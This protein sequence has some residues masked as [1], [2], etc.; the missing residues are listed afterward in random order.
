MNEEVVAFWSSELR[1]DHDTI[2]GITLQCTAKRISGYSSGIWNKDDPLE[3]LFPALILRITLF[4]FISRFLYVLLRPL[5][6]S[7]TVCNTL[8]GFILGPFSDKFIKNLSSRCNQPLVLFV[9]QHWAWVGV[10]YHVFLLGVKMDTSVI[11]RTGKKV[12]TI[13]LAGVL[14]S[15]VGVPIWSVMNSGTDIIPMKQGVWMVLLFSTSPF[16]IVAEALEELNLLTSELG[17]FA[18]SASMLIDVLRW[19][20]LAVDASVL[21][22]PYAFSDTVKRI[23]A[24]IGLILLSVYVMRPMMQRIVKRTPEKQ[25]VASV[26]HFA[27]LLAV[28]L[29]AF[30]SLTLGVTIVIGPLLFGLAVPDG[31]PLGAPLVDKSE[32][33]I[34]EFFMPCFYLLIGQF[35]RPFTQTWAAFPKIFAIVFSVCLGKFL[36]V[37]IAAL[38]NK[39]SLRHAVALGLMLNVKGWPEQMMFMHW[40]RYKLIA[41]STYTPSAIATVSVTAIVTP[42]IEFL[43]KPPWRLN[44][45]LDE[46]GNT[47]GTMPPNSQLRVLPCVYSEEDVDSIIPLLEASSSTGHQNLF[48]AYVIHLVELSGRVTPLFE[49]YDTYK[50]MMGS[51]Q[52]A[53]DRIVAAFDKYFRTSHSQFPVKN[54]TM[55]APFK[56]MYESICKL[57]HDEF[58]PLIIVPFHRNP[59]SQTAQSSALREVNMQLQTYAP[60]TV[61]ILVDKGFRRHSTMLKFSYGIAVIFIGGP[62]DREVLAFASHLLAHPGVA[63]TV[64]RIFASDPDAKDKNSDDALEK[65]LDDAVTNE[66]RLKSLKNPHVVY[67]DI[68]VEDSV[69]LWDAIRSLDNNYDLVMVGRDHGANKLL[70]PEL[71]DWSENAELGAVGDML[72]SSDFHGGTISVLVMQHYRDA[73]RTFLSNAMSVS[74]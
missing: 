60:C 34:E 13:A 25:P 10:I 26:Y 3:H 57:A 49:T 72:A 38:H 41:P 55:I 20:L 15:I 68:K 62:D 66:F 32:R 42:L 44:K 40:G 17:R 74:T 47:I 58:I 73:D 24:L 35:V 4:F 18:M 50:M 64:W 28:A 36:G 48:S 6:Q 56:G 27:I 69:Q 22:Q 45:S 23:G 1:K 33:L 67:H 43:Y 31:M 8:A 46:F 11:T 12:W 71:Q 19:I 37:M 59:Q 2:G 16:P 52:T 29:M 5:R 63:M 61:G 70:V 14:A 9:S 21:Q 7:R 54:F 53:S 65:Q 51:G 39:M 30:L